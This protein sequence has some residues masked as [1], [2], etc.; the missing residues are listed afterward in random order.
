MDTKEVTVS[1]FRSVYASKQLTVAKPTDASIDHRC[2]YTDTTG[3]DEN[4][5]VR[6]VPFATA[7]AFC[8][9]RGGDLPTAAQWEY[10]ARGRGLSYRYPW[11]NDAPQCCTGSLASRAQGFSCPENLDVGAFAKKACTTHDVTVD[12]VLDLGGSV[13]EWVQDA[14][15]STA[16]CA[17]LGVLPDTACTAP[18]AAPG[19]TKGGS[20]MTPLE[21]ASA[22]LRREPGEL[23]DVGFR[24]V[25]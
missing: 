22:A 20:F 18:G 4:E 15:I 14:P 24:C 16:A 25:R 19:S 8:R 21:G 13:R 2:N 7:R 6:C 3:A 9:A 5:A 10:A 11:G 1:L 12:G 17:G 23:V